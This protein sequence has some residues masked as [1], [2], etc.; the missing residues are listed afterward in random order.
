MTQYDN[1]SQRCPVLGHEVP[2][3]YCRKPAQDVPCRKIF[4]CW[5]EK[6]DIKKYVSDNFTDEVQQ[7]I[8][9]P[10]KPKI[11]SLLEIIEQAKKNSLKE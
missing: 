8:L 6:I 7:N 2:F 5:W 9:K 11:M 10:P 4:D 1:L 3:S